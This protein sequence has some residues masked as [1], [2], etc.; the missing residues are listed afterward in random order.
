MGAS[1]SSAAVDG[2]RARLKAHDAVGAKSALRMQMQIAFNA[3]VAAHCEVAPGAHVSVLEMQSAICAYLAMVGM[4]DTVLRWNRLRGNR[5]P[6][7]LSPAY[8]PP[9][10]LFDDFGRD[11]AGV[12]TSGSVAFPVLAGIRVRSWPRSLSL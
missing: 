11:V 1:A 9:A 7:Y 4:S 12:E 3:F 2:A 10:Y 5:P 8:R 6:A